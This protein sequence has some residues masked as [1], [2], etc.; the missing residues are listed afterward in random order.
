MELENTSFIGNKFRVRGP[1]PGPHPAGIL[2]ARAA[3][4]ENHI[5][6]NRI[7]LNWDSKRFP[8]TT[9]QKTRYNTLDKFPISSEVDGLCLVR[10]PSTTSST[11]R[12]RTCW[13]QWA[14]IVER[15]DPQTLVLRKTNASITKP[16]AEEPPRCSSHR[17]RSNIQATPPLLGKNGNGSSL[18][19]PHNPAP[20]LKPKPAVR[21]LTGHGASSKTILRHCTLSLAQLTVLGLNRQIATPNASIG[22]KLVKEASDHQRG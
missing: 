3:P 9:Q 6:F 13:E 22:K 14:G 18:F 19:T 8:T 2:S 4:S 7:D 11:K 17:R 20:G 15:G 12:R 21:P 5:E 10:R 16:R 1:S